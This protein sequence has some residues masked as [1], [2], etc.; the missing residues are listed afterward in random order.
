MLS[1]VTLVFP[2][3]FVE[4]I[5]CYFHIGR[6]DNLICVHFVFKYKIINNAL[7]LG[8][9]SYIHYNILFVLILIGIGYCWKTNHLFLV[10]CVPSLK[11][12][13]VCWNLALFGS[14][15]SHSLPFST[16]KMRYVF[17]HMCFS[18]TLCSL[19]LALF[20]W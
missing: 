18:Y 3:D 17:E 13:R 16:L 15:L 2:F 5:L 14:C 8:E 9:L 20:T 11:V 7:I 1:F 6:C 10:L 4:L 19:A 12:W